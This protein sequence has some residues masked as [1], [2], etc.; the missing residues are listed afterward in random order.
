M[1]EKRGLKWLSLTSGHMKGR[2]E[3]MKMITIE[4]DGQDITGTNY[5]ET[6]HAGR[7]LVYVS[8]N[9]GCF[10]LL[11]PDARVSE[12][13]EMR[14]A[15]EVIVSRGPWPKMGRHDAVELMFEDD[16]DEPYALHLSTESFDRLPLPADRDRPG[17]EPRW[18]LSV[19]TTSGK[20]LELPCRYRVVKSIPC[21]KPWK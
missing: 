4:N 1:K 18:K 15:R 10:R 16:S 12:I 5:W 6:E 11:I 8:I 9:A 21:M 3:G 20:A 13:G 2:A 14:T 19:W 7:G 17:Q